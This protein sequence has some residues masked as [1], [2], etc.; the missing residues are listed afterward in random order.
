MLDRNRYGSKD[1]DG[2]RDRKRNNDSFGKSLFSDMFIMLKQGIL[3]LLSDSQ[4]Y[5]DFGFGGDYRDKDRQK[6]KKGIYSGNLKER[7]SRDF[8]DYLRIRYRFSKQD[9]RGSLDDK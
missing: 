8:R 3:E 4:D 9:R 6:G 2:K 5:L 1:Y 7:D